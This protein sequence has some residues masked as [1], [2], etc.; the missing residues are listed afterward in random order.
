M[1]YPLLND[2]F[3]GGDSVAVEESKLNAEADKDQ[4]LH[5]LAYQVVFT[6]PVTKALVDVRVP[7]QLLPSW[8]RR[9]LPAIRR[10]ADCN[11][12]SLQKQA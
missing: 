8:A 9:V 6:H 7:P 12:A 1:G 2:G 5:L 11:A 10:R 4:N 3:Y